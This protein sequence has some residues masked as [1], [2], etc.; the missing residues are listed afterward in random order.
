MGVTNFTVNSM[1]SIQAYYDQLIEFAEDVPI[2]DPCSD[3]PVS[4]HLLLTLSQSR[5]AHG[6]RAWPDQ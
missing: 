4:N 6:D 3:Y 5:G 2:G 1:P